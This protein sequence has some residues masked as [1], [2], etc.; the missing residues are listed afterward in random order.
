[1]KYAGQFGETREF[2]L[3]SA[4]LVGFRTPGE[5]IRTGPVSAPTETTT[6]PRLSHRIVV[7]GPSCC[8]EGRTRRHA[9]T[10]RRRAREGDDQGMD[11]R[12]GPCGLSVASRLGTRES[13]TPF[14]TVS[15]LAS[16]DPCGR[17][18]FP[19]Q[20]GGGGGNR[21]RA[22]PARAGDWTSRLARW[23]AFSAARRAQS[24]RAGRRR[25]NGSWSRRRP[26]RAEQ[27]E[28]KY[29]RTSRGHVVPSVVETVAPNPATS[30]LPAVNGARLGLGTGA[31]QL[32]RQKRKV[33]WRIDLAIDHH[34]SARHRSGLL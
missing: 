28:M 15:W 14:L 10:R 20:P 12:M 31:W 8:E 19:A 21:D 34:P 7:I 9:R 32:F 27:K 23:T 29:V 2:L 30:S 33:P 25:W 11:G 5:L 22:T 17:G 1:V 16:S 4:S 13:G 24:A 6:R 26:G 3:R 18:L